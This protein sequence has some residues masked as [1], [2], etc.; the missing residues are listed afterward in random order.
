MSQNVISWPESVASRDFDNFLALG[1]FSYVLEIV[2]LYSG[3]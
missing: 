3:K 1:W 2:F